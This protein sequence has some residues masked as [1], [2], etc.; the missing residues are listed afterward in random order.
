[1]IQRG[2]KTNVVQNDGK[3]LLYVVAASG[4]VAMFTLL[5]ELDKIGDINALDDL[6]P[7]PFL[8]AALKGD[9]MMAEALLIEEQIQIFLPATD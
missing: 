3:S 7:T 8:L 9:N 6:G 5:A 1:L 4:Q 2:A